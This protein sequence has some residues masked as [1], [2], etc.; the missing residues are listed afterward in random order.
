MTNLAND[1][2][3]CND[4]VK[5]SEHFYYKNKASGR[6]SKY[7]KSCDR[8]EAAAR[9]KRSD[10][11][12]GTNE[13]LSTLLTRLTSEQIDDIKHLVQLRVPKKVVAEKYKLDVARFQRYVA[14]G[15]LV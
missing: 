14:Q 9:F 4:E 5:T 11:Y 3:H 12:L 13:K 8:K 15:L 6:L 2:C 7:C 10:K 1:T